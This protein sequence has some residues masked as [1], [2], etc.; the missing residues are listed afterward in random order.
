MRKYENIILCNRCN[1]SKKITKY[2]CDTCKKEIDYDG[3]NKHKHKDYHKVVFT[4]HF[5]YANSES[6]GKEFCSWTCLF[7]YLI[8]M[9]EDHDEIELPE[10]HHEHLKEFMKWIRK[11]D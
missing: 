8:N 9:K 5:E 7:K 3:W 10:I 1:N 6:D 4:D 2:F 11:D